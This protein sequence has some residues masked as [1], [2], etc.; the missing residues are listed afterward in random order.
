MMTLNKLD[1]YANYKRERFLREAATERLA[2]QVKEPRS[3]HLTRSQRLESAWSCL[4]DPGELMHR[5]AGFLRRRR[6]A[7]HAKTAQ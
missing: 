5:A 6:W 1:E 4:S 3:V 7:L 2:A